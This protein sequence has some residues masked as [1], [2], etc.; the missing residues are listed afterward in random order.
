MD[1][2]KVRKTTEKQTEMTIGSNALN[3]CVSFKQ[4]VNQT[5]LY[6]HCL[7]CVCCSSWAEALVADCSKEDSHCRELRTGNPVLVSHREGE[8]NKEDRED[9]VEVW[10]KVVPAKVGLCLLHI[11]A[12]FKTG[13]QGCQGSEVLPSLEKRK[14]YVS[15]NRIKAEKGLNVVLI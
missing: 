3:I 7:A 4:Q 13:Q 11:K 2:K 10:L 1:T 12:R 9:K 8:N 5:D 15:Q 6:D 14:R